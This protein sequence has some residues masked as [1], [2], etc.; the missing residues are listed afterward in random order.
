M[1]VLITW[2]YSCSK[3]EVPRED[4]ETGGRHRRKFAVGRWFGIREC[5][6]GTK[7][8]KRLSCSLDIRLHHMLRRILLFQTTARATSWNKTHLSDHNSSMNIGYS[9]TNIRSCQ[10]PHC[11][12]LNH[13]MSASSALTLSYWPPPL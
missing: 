7:V 10:Y 3:S 4:Y 6:R 1:R 9:S 2:C 11:F 12:L 8:R 5:E 13:Y